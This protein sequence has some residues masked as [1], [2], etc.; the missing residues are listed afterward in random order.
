MIILP[1]EGNSNFKLILQIIPGVRINQYYEGFKLKNCF[2]II[3][4]KN[5]LKI[6]HSNK[7][8]INTYIGNIFNLNV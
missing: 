5:L 8:N 1:M 4:K 3:R 2:E 7:Y 6:N